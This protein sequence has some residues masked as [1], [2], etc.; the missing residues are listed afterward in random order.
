MSE[1]TV[2]IDLGASENLVVNPNPEEIPYNFMMI[3]RHHDPFM[4]KWGNFCSKVVT[5]LSKRTD[6]GETIRWYHVKLFNF[7]YKQYDKYGDY[8][9][10]ID[11]SYGTYE[12]DGIYEVI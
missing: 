5:K 1:K 8:Y 11:N 2:T 3:H 10:I 6:V 12:Q 9:K 4:Q 7:C